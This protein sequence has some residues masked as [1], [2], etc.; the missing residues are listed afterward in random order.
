MSSGERV[1]HFNELP[2]ADQ[3]RLLKIMLEND[4][5]LAALIAAGANGDTMAA[6]AVLA[7]NQVVVVQRDERGN[8]TSVSRH[9]K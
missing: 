4:G 9:G 1:Q 7:F 8:V 6:E 5:V 2:Q 3:E